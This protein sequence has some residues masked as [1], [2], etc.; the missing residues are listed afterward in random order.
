M[1]KLD[2]HE[3]IRIILE[4][5][6]HPPPPY[7]KIGD[8]VA[9]LP[10]GE[11]NLV[12]KVDMLV[13]KTDVPTGM[14]MWQVAR[15]SLV[16]CVS[17][18]AA[19]GVKPKASLL[20]LGLPSGTTRQEVRQLAAGFRRAEEEFGLA[21]VGG[22]TN[23]AEDVIID[24][25][26]LSFAEKVT[27]RHGASVGDRLVVTGAFGYPP[28][29]LKVL[30]EG[31]TVPAKMRRKIVS[32]VLLPTPK[33]ELGVAL[34]ESNL[35]S[36]AIDSSD[37]LALSLYQLAEAGGVGFEVSRLPVDGEVVSV[38]EEGGLDV[39]DL[40][41]YGG[42]EYEV[43]ATVPEEKLKEAHR[44][45]EALGFSLLEIGRV[46]DDAGRVVFNDGSQSFEVE[47]R[48]WVHLA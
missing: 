15:K 5:V 4:T 29:G 17:D 43:V 45:A 38:A 2:E 1:R 32:S 41:F 6:G 44:V 3:V 8:D 31:F 16:E 47:R 23:E 12:V 22:D 19:K 7:S 42:E 24:C 10:L 13:R 25:C 48:G 9:I 27:G 35:L 28:L 20:S 30:Q 33:L 21:I 34:T 11:G 39:V 14:K 37:G 40:V 18:F 46:T 36:S 26:M